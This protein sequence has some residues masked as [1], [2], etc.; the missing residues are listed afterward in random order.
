MLFKRK[1]VQKETN[2]GAR[3][4][5]DIGG[6]DIKYAVVEGTDIKLQKKVPTNQESVEK[7]MDEIVAVCKELHAEYPYEK[8]G[9]GAPGVIYDGLLSTDNLPFKNYPIAE[10]LAKRLGMPVMVDNDA[11]CAALGEIIAG[12]GNN[13]D[14]AILVTLGTGVGG[15]V[16]VDRKILRGRGGAGE[17]GHMIIQSENGLPCNCGATGCW[18]QYASVRA[19]VRQ[20]VEAAE[21]HPESVLGGLYR[22]NGELNGVLIFEALD[23]H[24][25][26]A[27]AVFDT[28]LDWICVGVYSLKMI[29]DPEVILFGGGITKRGDA[30]LEP[31]KKKLNG[32]VCVKIAKLQNEAGALGAAFLQN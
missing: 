10:E 17:L 12:D 11:N 14:N 15:G 21:K 13:Y 18:E 7:L 26:V 24:C 4:G 2:I 16:I 1:K 20:A 29:F 19:F 31:L 6:T 5:V 27:E 9:V 32:L 28:Y 8:I 30:F 22:E 23:K 25:P 3:L